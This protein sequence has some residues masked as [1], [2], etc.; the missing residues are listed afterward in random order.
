MKA[1]VLRS[2]RVIAPETPHEELSFH[3][4]QAFGMGDRSSVLHPTF[5]GA[6]F[7]YA[8]AKRKGDQSNESRNLRQGIEK[9]DGGRSLPSLRTREQSTAL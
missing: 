9:F 7:S 2:R 4:I 5:R 8:H 6:L 1:F 3:L